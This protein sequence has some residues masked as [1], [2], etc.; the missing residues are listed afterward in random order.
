VTGAF[1]V[2]L[3]PLGPGDA[4][5]VAELET[6]LFGASAWTEAM[7][8]GELTAPGRW[9][10]AADDPTDAALDAGD[11]AG[12]GGGGQPLV[13]YA[14]LWFDGDVTQVMTI[15]VAPT[16]QRQGIGGALLGALVERSRGLGAT[17]VL[18]E[19]RVDNEQALALYERFGFEVLGRR[20]RYYQPEDADAWTMRLE[21]AGPAT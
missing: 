15:G 20:R 14:G 9:Y 16:M 18:L 19:V 6:E 10:V 12:S 7:I 21:L 8:R 11:G 13:G 17:A 5:R 1:P 4:S 2:P 3:R